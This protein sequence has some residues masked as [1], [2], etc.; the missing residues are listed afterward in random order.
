MLIESHEVEFTDLVLYMSTV[1]TSTVSDV[2]HCFD[3]NLFLFQTARLAVSRNKLF[4]QKLFQKNTRKI[5]LI[6]ILVTGTH[7]ED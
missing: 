4:L 1:F 5:S 7:I 2:S 6:F 3:P